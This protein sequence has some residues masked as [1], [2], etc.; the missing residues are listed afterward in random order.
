MKSEPL[1]SR[2]AAREAAFKAVYSVT[3]SGT[4]FDEAVLPEAT[5]AHLDEEG[6]TFLERLVRLSTTEPEKLDESF[7]SFLAADWQLDRLAMTD[8]I[9]LRMACAEL[10][11]VDDVPPK[12]T[13]NEYVSLA[14]LYGS[15]DS[16]KFVNGVLGKVLPV[17]PKANWAGRSTSS[18][19]RRPKAAQAASPD[20][21]PAKKGW[22]V[23]SEG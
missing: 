10:W 19:A 12:V 20:P 23:R 18:P 14:K 16:G 22:T 8:K 11:F 4:P 21:K 6:Q 9:A 3:L 13:I 15:A 1:S 2:K 5:G 17:C 7:S